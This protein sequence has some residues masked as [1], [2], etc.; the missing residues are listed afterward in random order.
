MYIFGTIYY[1]YMQNKKNLNA[2][3]EKVKTQR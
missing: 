1:A 2:R 3:S